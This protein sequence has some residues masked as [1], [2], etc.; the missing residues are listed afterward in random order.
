[1][2]KPVTFVI[3]VPPGPSFGERQ[4]R[5]LVEAMLKKNGLTAQITSRERRPGDTDYLIQPPLEETR[6]AA[7][8]A[9]A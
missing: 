6:S 8:T 4:G 2:A 9:S 5:I 3:V 7:E 1:M